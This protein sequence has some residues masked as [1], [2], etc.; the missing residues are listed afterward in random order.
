MAI[1][2]SSQ[3]NGK[4]QDLSTICV[5]ASNI[6]LSFDTSIEIQSR[7][8]ALQG[9]NNS[10]NFTTT[11]ATALQFVLI[12]QIAIVFKLWGKLANVPSWRMIEYWWVDLK[13]NPMISFAVSSRNKKIIFYSIIM[14]LYEI[15]RLQ[16]SSS[17]Y[18]LYKL[19]YSPLGYSV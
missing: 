13:N 15:C 12:T 10:T 4:D 7:Y 19:V 6:Q 16:G 8:I 11:T 2:F 14:L 3:S 1:K 18:L 5:P 9:F 17:R